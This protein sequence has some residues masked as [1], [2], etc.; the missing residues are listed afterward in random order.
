MFRGVCLEPTKV[1]ASSVEIL[2]GLAGVGGR[3]F[4]GRV[5]HLSVSESSPARWAAE[6]DE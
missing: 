2:Q 4:E 3:T 6:L 1:V 5:A